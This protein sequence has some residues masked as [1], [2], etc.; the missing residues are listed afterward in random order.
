M[1]KRPKKI[2]KTVGFFIHACSQAVLV[3]SRINLAD[4]LTQNISKFVE[5]L[6]KEETDEK[7]K[8]N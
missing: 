6:V 5:K 1:S 3:D 7:T 2:E 4:C 8:E